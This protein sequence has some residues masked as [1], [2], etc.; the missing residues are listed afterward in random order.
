VKS[1]AQ[2]E[3]GVAPS[4]SV[5][6]LPLHL[7]KFSQEVRSMVCTLVV[8]NGSAYHL[9][10]VI[11]EESRLQEKAAD[12]LQSPGLDKVFTGS[13]L[14][15]R[16]RRTYSGAKGISEGSHNAQGS[17]MNQRCDTAAPKLTE[18]SQLGLRW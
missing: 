7:S 5:G 18:S 1:F 15:I 4:T 6:R 11:L 9:A 13:P 14:M 3:H 8:A 17:C 2:I 12:L 10:R 16:H